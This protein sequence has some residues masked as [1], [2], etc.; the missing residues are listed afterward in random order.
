M[1]SDI[2]RTAEGPRTLQGCA[3]TACQYCRCQHVGLELC[4]P[5][6]VSVFEIGHV[7]HMSACLE[8]GCQMDIEGKERSV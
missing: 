2:D 3:L 7:S 5:S 8:S 6:Y 4:S 1:T